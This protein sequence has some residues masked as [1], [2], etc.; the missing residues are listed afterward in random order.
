MFA[1]LK[2]AVLRLGRWVG[3]A[4]RSAIDPVR[5][6]RGLEQRIPRPVSKPTS[7]NTD[8]KIIEVPMLNGLHHVYEW[9][10]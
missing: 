1:A 7:A 4:I 6:A 9:A 3:G 2:K 10:A 5:S 8:A